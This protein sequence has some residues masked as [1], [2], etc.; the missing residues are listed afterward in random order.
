MISIFISLFCFFFQVLCQNHCQLQNVAGTYLLLLGISN[1]AINP[2]VYTYTN[3]ELKKHMCGICRKNKIRIVTN[4][5][6]PMPSSDITPGTPATNSN[7]LSVPLHGW[8]S[9]PR[10][11]LISNVSA[12]SQCSTKR[13]SIESGTRKLSS[14]S[15]LKLRQVNIAIKSKP[16]TRNSLPNSSTSNCHFTLPPS[17]R[18]RKLSQ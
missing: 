11:S 8:N 15:R 5:S 10:S 6:Q 2:I 18:K 7:F 16:V 9:V 1:S 12:Y 17:G 4:H 14:V 13:S 3:R